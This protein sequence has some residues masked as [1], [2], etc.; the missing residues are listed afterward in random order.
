MAAQLG[1]VPHLPWTQAKVAQSAPRRQ[2]CPAPHATQSE[3]PQS[4]SVSL[5]LR[6]PSMHEMQVMLCE[7]HT[8]LAQ[9]TVR[10]HLRPLPHGMQV[11]PPQSTSV[12]SPLCTPSEQ[13]P[14]GNSKSLD[15]GRIL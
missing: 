6:S 15:G 14:G 8:E 11:G 1:G 4:T 9:S 12:S 13:L 3:P 7:S 2:V 10:T 5:P